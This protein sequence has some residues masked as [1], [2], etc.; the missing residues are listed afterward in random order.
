MKQ[1]KENCNLIL[2][3]I[4]SASNFTNDDRFFRFLR[5]CKILHISGK[6]SQNL[7]KVDLKNLDD[8]KKEKTNKSI[9]LLN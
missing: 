2:M 5:I 9:F 7:K 8:K 4:F 1:G 3:E 6:K